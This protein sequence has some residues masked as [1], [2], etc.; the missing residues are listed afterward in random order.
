MKYAVDKQEK[1]TLIRLEEEKLDTTLAPTLKTD[2]L[3]HH[4]EGIRNLILD[5]STVRYIDSSGLSSLLVGNRVFSEDGGLFVLAG[6]TD[7]VM[8]LI[9]IS[10]LDTVLTFLPTV[11]EAVEAVF[12][13]EIERDLTE[14]GD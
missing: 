7:H 2:L 4:A 10:Q 14:E 11:E 12:M 6:I 13:N 9:K 1:Y 8:K 5:L 3:T